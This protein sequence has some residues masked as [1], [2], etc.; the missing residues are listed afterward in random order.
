VPRDPL[1]GDPVIAHPSSRFE[2][3]YFLQ[4]SAEN[5]WQASNQFGRP[6]FGVSGWI[7][8]STTEPLPEG[9]ARV[10][11]LANWGFRVRW[12]PHLGR[13]GH[14]TILLVDPVDD[15]QA[16]RFNQSFGREPGEE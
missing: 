2:E 13:R 7:V 11:T 9:Y 14:V 15:E 16:L 4:R 6:L 5:T 8:A 12:T 3:A 1:E 10:S